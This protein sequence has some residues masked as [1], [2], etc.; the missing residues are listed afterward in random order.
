MNSKQL[1]YFLVTAQNGSIASAARELDIAQ[2]AIS[3]QLANLE[4]EM[5]A[6]LLAR[7]F[8]GVSLTVAGEVFARH[9]KKLIDDINLAK[10][11]LSQLSTITKGKI[12]L[13]MLPSIGNVLS[14]SLIAEV[15]R[16][17]PQLDLEISTGPSYSVKEWLRTNRIDIALTYEQEIDSK[18]MKTYPLIEEFMYLVVGVNDSSANYQELKNRDSISFWELSQYEL[19]TPGVKDALGRLIDKYEKESGVALKHNK[20]YSGQ[21]MTGLRQVMQGEGMMIL[22]SSAIFHLEEK[23]LLKSLKIINPDMTRQA[24]IATNNGIA[25]SDKCLWVIDVIKRVTA[26]EQKLMHWRGQLNTPGKLR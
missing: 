24:L 9:A 14:M 16:W 12:R 13:G 15:N 3:Q 8:K 5:G 11:E 19:L 25:L 18:Y 26:V 10:A 17:H 21:L 20:A 7:S 23:S 22:P 2:P 1:H 6:E 4:R